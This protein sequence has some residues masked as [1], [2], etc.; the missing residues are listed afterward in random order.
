[1][2]QRAV[3]CSLVIALLVCQLFSRLCN[4]NILNCKLY[5]RQ[6]ACHESVPF[7]GQAQRS[8]RQTGSP[9]SRFPPNVHPFSLT[10]QPRHIASHPSARSFR[11]SRN[12]DG[13]LWPNEPLQYP[14]CIVSNHSLGL[15]HGLNPCTDCIYDL[16]HQKAVIPHFI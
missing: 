16:E 13:S 1:M 2:E 8:T 12:N 6:V 11:E 9:T 10:V 3:L 15:V 7:M 4:S 14:Y 5:T